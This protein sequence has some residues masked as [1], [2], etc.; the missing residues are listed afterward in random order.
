M[1]EETTIRQ[2]F[3]HDEVY[4]LLRDAL[5]A[6]PEIK[7][8]FVIAFCTGIRKGELLAVKWDAVDLESGF[9]DLA[10]G[11]TKNGEGRRVPILAGDMID[12][13][14]AAK[15][16][17]DE[18]FPGCPWVFHRSGKRVIDFRTCWTLATKAA[19]VPELLFH[20]LRRTAVRNMRKSGVSQK[21]RM[22]ISGHKSDSMERRYNIVDD[23][24]LQH[25]KT[26][27]E[28]KTT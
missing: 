7:L 19:G 18:N 8:L 21:V 22:K 28:R 25:A 2:G 9:L 26:L 6:E 11:T 15:Q 27:M 20:D 4:P 24:D 5:T 13:L 1:R 16:F 3:L 10:P 17:R 23:E 14:T 12:L